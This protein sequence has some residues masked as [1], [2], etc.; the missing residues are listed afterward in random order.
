MREAVE[1]PVG[2]LGRNAYRMECP[3]PL[4]HGE[5]PGKGVVEGAC[6]TV[7]GQRLKL[8]GG[9]RPESWST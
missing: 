2:Y 9:L 5:C 4:S 6:E 3:E 7:V 1:E 8:V